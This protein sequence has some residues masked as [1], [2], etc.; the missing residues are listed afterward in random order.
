MIGG[1][2]EIKGDAFK[3]NLGGLLLLRMVEDIQPATKSMSIC[4]A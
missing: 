3:G 2:S 1:H 4:G